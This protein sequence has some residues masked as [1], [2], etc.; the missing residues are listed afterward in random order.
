[1]LIVLPLHKVTFAV[2]GLTAGVLAASWWEN[3]R[4]P[5][6]PPDCDH[7]DTAVAMPA[8]MATDE[9]Q[10]TFFEPGGLYTAADIAANGKTPPAAKF[11]GIKAQ[12]DDNPKVGERLCPISM[13]KANPKFTWVIGGKSYEF[14]CVPCIEEFVDIAKTKPAEIHPPGHYIKR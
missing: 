12:H 8:K 1:M 11:K 10:K 3:S 6:P 7:A 14:C 13:T 9:E 5:T 4:Q 2:L